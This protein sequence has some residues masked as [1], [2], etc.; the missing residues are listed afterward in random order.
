[1]IL[2][3]LKVL[4][5]LS[6]PFVCFP[7]FAQLKKFNQL[8]MELT[9]GVHVPMMTNGQ[10]SRDGF[11]SFKQFQLSGRYMFNHNVGLKAHYGFNRFEDP[12]DYKLGV[13]Y[14]R[15][16]VEGVISL[17]RLGRVHYLTREYVGLLLHA[18]A[19]VTVGESS[20]VNRSDTFAN[21]L[22]GFT[23]QVKLFENVSL[24]G[25]LSYIFN[26]NQKYGY[27]GRVFTDPA[28]T[29]FVNVSIG[30]MYSIG[31]YKYHADWY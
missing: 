13:S 27:N 18:G 25:D 12:G 24:L 17:S 6:I 10:T 22:A 4:L 14:N 5:V 8:S 7:S 26:I 31:N 11:I 9:S 15:F 3:K 1:M 2:K 21:L 20:Y 28:S 30:L 16:G 19:G 29:S 23:A